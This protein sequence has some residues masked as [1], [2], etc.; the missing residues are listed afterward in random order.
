M[1]AKLKIFWELLSETMDE[2][3]EDHVAKFSASLAYYT[4][5]SVGPLLMVLVYLLGLVYHKNASDELFAQIGQYAGA[6]NARQLQSILNNLNVSNSSRLFNII[7]IVV[8]VYSS[9]SI[10]TEIQ[11]SINYMWDIKAKPKRGWVKIL[12]NRLLSFLLILGS[13]LLLLVSLVLN[14]VVDFVTGQLNR[15]HFLQQHFKNI[16]VGFLSAMNTLILFAIVTFLFFVFFMVLPDGKIHWKDG[17]VGASFTGVLFLIGKFLITWYLTSSKLISAYG[18]AASLIILLSWVY[19][20]AMILYFGAEFTDVYAR[21]CG[22]GVSV[23]KTAVFIIKREAKELP[24]MKTHH[25]E[26]LH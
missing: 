7:G 16:D 24:T 6:D 14:V 9:T 12:A 2:Y 17:L 5:F 8:F 21:K 15:F 22:R 4:I 25:E 11:S 23:K 18:A 3:V 26:P 1:L 13:G 20:S 10:F 19:Y